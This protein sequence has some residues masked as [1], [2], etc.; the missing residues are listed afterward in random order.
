MLGLKAYI[1]TTRPLLKIFVNYSLGVLWAFELMLVGSPVSVLFITKARV[2]NF[3]Q[4]NRMSD[5]SSQPIA[6]KNPKSEDKVLL[7]HFGKMN[8]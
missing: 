2:S 1:S 5:S 6:F 7:N 8:R 4:R 3:A